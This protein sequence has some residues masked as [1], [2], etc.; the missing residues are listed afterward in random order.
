MWLQ[1]P[2]CDSCKACVST[3]YVHST[4]EREVQR[5]EIWGLRVA[6]PT[7]TVSFSVVKNFLITAISISVLKI[8]GVL[9]GSYLQ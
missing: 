1:H 4:K 5:N 9:F 2:K 3:F 8:R 6:A 7:V